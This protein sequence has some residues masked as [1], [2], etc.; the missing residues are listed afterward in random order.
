MT[1]IDFSEQIN[2]KMVYRNLQDKRNFYKPLF[3]LEDLVRTAD[4]K[5]FFI[6]S[7]S[8]KW[9]YKIIYNY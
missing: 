7:D 4:I 1:L 8:K 6:K 3:K 9:S 5:I 2:A